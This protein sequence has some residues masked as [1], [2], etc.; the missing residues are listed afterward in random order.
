MKLRD[1]PLLRDPLYEAD[2]LAVEAVGVLLP[3]RPL[4]D[5]PEERPPHHVRETVRRPAATLVAAP[6][7]S[8]A[9]ERFALRRV[10]FTLVRACEAVWTVVAFALWTL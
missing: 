5:L 3:R 6:P 4:Q 1:S 10:L 7:E 9:V 8:V 2:L